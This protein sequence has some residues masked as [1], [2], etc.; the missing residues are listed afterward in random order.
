MTRPQADD[1]LSA[2]EIA[3][4]HAIPNFELSFEV[5]EN[6]DF[7]LTPAIL[8]QEAIADTIVLTYPEQ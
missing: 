7:I 5:R 2:R 4:R 6:A 3:T 8:V 1:R